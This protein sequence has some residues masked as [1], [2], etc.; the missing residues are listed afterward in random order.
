MEFE[1]ELYCSNYT[2]QQVLVKT[3]DLLCSLWHQ[4]FLAD[5]SS[6]TDTSTT[7]PSIENESTI[8]LQQLLITKLMFFIPLVQLNEPFTDLTARL[9]SFI[10]HSHNP[11]LLRKFYELILCLAFHSDQGQKTI[12]SEMFNHLSKPN[13]ISEHFSILAVLVAKFGVQTVNEQEIVQ[14]LMK[15]IF[16]SNN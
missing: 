2:K 3:L 1:Q 13:I 6:K 5:T 4:Q 7:S 15:N 11:K 16:C 8:Y 14:V 12:I 9:E 10:S